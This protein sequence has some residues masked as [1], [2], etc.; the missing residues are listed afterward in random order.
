MTTGEILAFAGLGVGFAGLIIHALKQAVDYGALRQRVKHLEDAAVDNKDIA[1]LVI[2][3]A[4]K[5]DGFGRRLDEVAGG[6]T[7]LTKV[8]PEEAGRQPARSRR[9]GAKP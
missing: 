3:M 6:L 2:Q 4:E 5:V 1:K 7:W 8:P 9:P